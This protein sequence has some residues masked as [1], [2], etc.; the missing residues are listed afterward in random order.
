MVPPPSKIS[1]ILEPAPALINPEEPSKSKADELANSPP[2]LLKV[3]AWKTLALLETLP[4]FATTILEGL[5]VVPI[6]LLL[7]SS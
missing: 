3:E 2:R 5:L 1:S 4:P 7:A 6:A